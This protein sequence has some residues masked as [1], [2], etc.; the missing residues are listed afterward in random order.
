MY[1][2][3]SARSLPKGQACLDCRRRKIRCD[4]VRPICGPCSR[5]ERFEDCEYEGSGTPN[6]R[7]LEQSVFQV[8]SRIMELEHQGRPPSLM[9]ER[10]YSRG[11]RDTLDQIPVQILRQAL[12]L[13]GPCA[14]EVGFFLNP[15]RFRYACLHGTGSDELPTALVS[16][17]CLWADCISSTEPMASQENNFLSRALKTATTVLSSP[18][19][20]KIIYGIQTET[21]LCQYFL[22]KGRLLEAQY[23]LSVAVSYVVLGD[24]AS[25]R[26][27]RGSG[28][29][30]SPIFLQDCV[31]EGEAIIAFWTVF[32]LDKTL[33]S[34]L[35]F[36]SNFASVQ[37]DIPWPLEMEDY[38][39]KQVP[40]QVQS[41]HTVQR[42]ME[43][44]GGDNRDASCLAILAKSAALLDGATVIARRWRANMA[45]AEITAFLK[46]FMKLNDRIKNFRDS[47]PP[48]NS[49]AGCTSAAKPRV[50]LAH[51]IAHAATIQLNRAFIAVNPRCREL[52]LA[53]CTSIV[54]IVRA[55]GLRDVAY[56]NPIIGSLWLLTSQILSQEIA[57]LRTVPN[58]GAMVAD[59]TSA[60]DD[61]AASA[62]L[63]SK[64]C[65][66]MLYQVGQL[67][68]LNRQM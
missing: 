1:S 55:A 54:W 37:V 3:S 35:D 49:L 63:F 9:L 13:F 28:S 29:S 36:P 17:V 18:H 67:G 14:Q 4:S 21:F 6:I 40:P 23:H 12:D 22:Y 30:Q 27:S 68:S 7:K 33:C 65:P 43:D 39:R 15:R 31:E 34:V 25:I 59:L 60:N 16:C 61:I 24:L 10:P 66:F 44:A 5:A 56:L 62:A 26:S 64:N 50:I 58:A 32:W 45:P 42:F 47:L 51:T 48:P 2:P 46:P 52:S 19:R 41:A 20:L 11:S 57:Q 53:A 8:E 38:E